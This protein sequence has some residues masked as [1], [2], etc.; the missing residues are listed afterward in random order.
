MTL[1][2]KL[3]LLGVIAIFIIGGLLFWFL[4]KTLTF[5]KAAGVLLVYMGIAFGLA[6]ILS[7]VYKNLK[8]GN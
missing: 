6:F 7:I 3:K 5:M 8:G 2:Q 4:G 1:K